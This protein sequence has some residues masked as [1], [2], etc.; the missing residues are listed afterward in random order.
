VELFSWQMVCF[1]GGSG[2]VRTAA[3]IEWWNHRDIRG[4]VYHRRSGEREQ[5]QNVNG[6]SSVI[7]DRLCVKGD[8]WRKNGIR[9]CTV[10]AS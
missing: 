2:G 10:E 7:L 1:Y 3:E 4:Y 6:R 9:V 8:R 5:L